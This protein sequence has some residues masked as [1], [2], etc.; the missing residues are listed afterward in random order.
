MLF[1]KIK[2]FQNIKD[3]KDKQE[4]NTSSMKFTNNYL[5][6]NKKINLQMENIVIQDVLQELQKFNVSIEEASNALVEDRLFMEVVKNQLEEINFY[7]GRCACHRF[8]A[9]FDWWGL[10]LHN[11]WLV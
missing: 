7:F 4:G 8:W 3:C 11:R 6:L 5:S 9:D 1:S 10:D 2:S